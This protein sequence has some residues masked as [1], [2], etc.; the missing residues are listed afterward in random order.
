MSQSAPEGWEAKTAGR[1][2]VIAARIS[3]N[4]VPNA[5]YWHTGNQKSDN[6]A[7]PYHYVRIQ[8]M[9][10]RD[11]DLLV[12]GGEDHPTGSADADGRHA[13]LEVWARKHFPINDVEYRW[14][15]QV[16]EPRDSLAFIGRNPRDK[17]KNIWVIDYDKI[18]SF[19]LEKGVFSSTLKIFSSG[20]HGDID[21]IDKEKAN[22]IIEIAHRSM[23][24]SGKPAPSASTSSVADELIKLAKLKEQGAIYDAEFLQMKQDLMKKI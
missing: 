4:D 5:L 13:A 11:Y 1:T 18:S 9:K 12:V 8:K 10:D 19:D 6:P 15:G 22:Q 14:S 3:K 20:Y 24:D 23:K 17:R 16:L 2:Y 21:A 7:P